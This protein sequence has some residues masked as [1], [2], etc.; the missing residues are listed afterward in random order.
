MKQPSNK[1]SQFW[2]EL[3]RRRVIHVIIVYATVAFVIIELVNN[4]FEPLRL[5]DWTPTMVI[6]V[7]IIGFPFAII[8]S[9]IFDVS[10]KG[11]KKT[12][13]AT[14]SE[15]VSKYENSIAVLPFQDMS[16][17]KNQEYFCDGM[18]EEI[19]NVL[20]HV[21]GLKVIARTSAFMF[22]DQHEDMRIIGQKLGVGHLLEGSIRKSEN[23]LRITAQ[24]IKSEDG[25]HVWSENFDRELKDVFVIQDEISL[26]IV[27]NLK[28][29]L[30]RSEKV[31]MLKHHTENSDLHNLYLLGRFYTNKRNTES[32]IKAIDYFQQAIRKDPNYAL[33]YAGLSEAYTLSGIGYGSLPSKEAYPKAKGG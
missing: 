22:K 32:L 27:E 3:K 14:T 19:I 6:I 21:E 29:R 5:P 30:P 9:W 7:L 16:S 18:T 11:I 2:H 10:L 33:A 23:R 17:E 25:T 12:E 1:L 26:A 4:V 8:F 20:S 15:Y 13:K 31:A 28:A 24:L